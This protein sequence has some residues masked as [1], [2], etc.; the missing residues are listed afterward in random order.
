MDFNNPAKVAETY[1]LVKKRFVK[2]AVKVK[3]DKAAELLKSING[4]LTRKGLDPKVKKSSS[5]IFKNK[6]QRGY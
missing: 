6:P 4:K 3:Y 5:R 1:E 2:E